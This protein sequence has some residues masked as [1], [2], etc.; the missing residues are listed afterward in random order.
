[1]RPEVSIVVPRHN[2]V[3]YVTTC[4]DSVSRQTIADDIEVIVVDDTST[5]ES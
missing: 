2:Y 5:D 3:G 4:I 1:M